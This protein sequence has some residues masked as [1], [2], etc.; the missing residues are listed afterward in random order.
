MCVVTAR[1]GQ[2]WVQRACRGFAMSSERKHPIFAGMAAG[3]LEG[4]NISFVDIALPTIQKYPLLHRCNCNG[5]PRDR[6]RT[7]PPDS[8]GPQ[9]PL[10]LKLL[11]RACV[12][13]A[14]SY[15]HV[16]ICTLILNHPTHTLYATRFLLSQV[17]S[18]F[19]LNTRKP[20]FKWETGSTLHWRSCGPL[21][22]SEGES[23]CS[24]FR[25]W[26]VM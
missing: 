20:S 15:C 13:A 19:R 9:L 22:K 24:W 14:I 11:Q 18:T 6:R 12:T 7:R 4:T 17:R 16:A 26:Y 3:L 23:Y 8:P 10:R 2:P 21:S 5:V 1:R 25:W